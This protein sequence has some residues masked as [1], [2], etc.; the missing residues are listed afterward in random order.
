MHSY[1][2]FQVFCYDSL[3]KHH[4][5]ESPSKR[6]VPNDQSFREAAA[7]L[8][9]SKNG[10]LM[11]YPP[12]DQEPD[13]SNLSRFTTLAFLNLLAH[14]LENVDEV[15]L[16]PESYEL[17]NEE[18]FRKWVYDDLLSKKNPNA[19]YKLMIHRGDQE[20]EPKKVLVKQVCT[21]RKYVTSGS[22]GKT[23]VTVNC[24]GCKNTIHRN[25]LRAP[26]PGLTADRFIDGFILPQQ[27][28][29]RVTYML[30]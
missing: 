24:D 10:F 14:C 11:I 29:T 3:W 1:S 2:I 7:S 17:P 9:P 12:V 6:F 25:C 28:C 18:R 5:L 23:A 27:G 15:E 22:R 21:C 26:S 19:I 4:S 30:I 8:V 16:V 20:E 13:N